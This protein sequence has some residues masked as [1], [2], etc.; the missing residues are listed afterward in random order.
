MPLRKS[1]A[2]R[3]KYTCRSTARLNIAAPQR[4]NH[5]TDQLRVLTQA[6]KGQSHAIGQI[7][8]EPGGLRRIRPF[9]SGL[10]Q[11]RH[12]SRPLSY[13]GSAFVLNDR[14]KRREFLCP[15]LHDA[16]LSRSSRLIHLCNRFAFTPCESARLAIDTPGCKHASTSRLFACGSNIRLPSR[17]TLIIGSP[18][19][20][21]SS[22]S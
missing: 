12:T 10:A 11:G 13:C 1:T 14:Y 22:M 5:R 19:H 4:F 16:L 18:S 15:V 3:C 6:L 2:S 17:F 21:D 7:G 9:A 8:I 20:T